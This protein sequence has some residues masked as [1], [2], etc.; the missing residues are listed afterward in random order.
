MKSLMIIG[1]MLLSTTPVLFARVKLV[2]L[3]ERD[4]IQIGLNQNKETLIEEDRTLNL[5]QGLNHIDFSWNGVQIDADSI[6]L[7]FLDDSENFTL[8][9]VSFPPGEKALVWQIA[10]K[11]GGSAPVRISYLLRSIDRLTTYRL[12]ADKDETSVDFKSYMVL[13]NFSGE[14]FSD[15][16]VVFD[17]QTGMNKQTIAH[18]ETRQLL[19]ENIGAVPFR[20]TWVFDTARL[21]W[22]PE[23]ISGNV[24]IPVYYEVDNSSASKLGR[25][26]LDAGRVRV[27]QQ[28]GHGGSIF[29]G[30]DDCESTPVGEKMKVYVGD[31]RDIVVTQRRVMNR[32]IN[33]RRN[34]SNSIVLYDT[35]EIITAKIENFKDSPATLLLIEYIPDQWD[36]KKC[37]MNYDRKEAGRLEFTIPLKPNESTELTMHYNRRN[38]R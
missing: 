12:T 9:N 11:N 4:G 29:L 1:L 18:E 7:Q 6:R 34:K 22:D 19:A 27:Y 10:A 31:S 8:L 33:V 5:Q 21:P 25:R 30:E 32:K 17:E 20:K 16:S 26:M 24:G 3:P 23:K 13:R 14:D 28:D 15:A 37:N 36:M 35:D 2:A 38:I